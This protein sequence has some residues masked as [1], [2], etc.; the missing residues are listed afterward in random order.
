MRILFVMATNTG[1]VGASGYAGAELMRL[2]HSHPNFDVT[3]ATAA[4]NAGQKLAD[5]HP[6]LLALG[7]ITLQETQPETLIG[8]DLVFVALP[9]GQSARLTQELPTSVKVV[10]LGAD[11]RLKSASDWDAYYGGEPAAQPWV[12]GLPELPDR[13]DL[14]VGASQVANPGCYATAMQLAAAPLLAAGLG[15]PE[16]V[17]VVAAS[18][19][20]GAGRKASIGLSATEV[21]GSMSA[22]K[23]GGIHPH[24]A[25]VIQELSLVAGAPVSLSFTPTL[26]PMP[27]GILATVTIKT[28]P[29]T[30]TSEV[31]AALQSAYE[32]SPFVNVLSDDMW[33]TTAATSGSNGVLL[34]ATVDERS[35]RAVV[36]A[37]IDNLGKGAAGQAI[38]NANLMCGL[39][40]TV[41]LSTM[42][43]TP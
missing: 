31:R 18:G 30:T 17:V 25:E 42:G 37:A 8:L 43:V 19:T 36:V 3:V 12:Y 33:P 27:R 15:Q 34:Q 40:E 38:Q 35:G 6:A 32:N 28:I 39:D 11:H 16:D 14:I 5:L 29:G 20:S 21:M 24:N 41:G 26:A 4:T 9:H 10:D 1:V 13:R 23:V 2:L 22:Y 7:A